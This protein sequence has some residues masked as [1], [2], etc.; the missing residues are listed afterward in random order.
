MRLICPPVNFAGALFPLSLGT[1]VIPRRNE[2]QRFCKIWGGGGG[3]GAN[4]LR[5]R[6]CV[7]GVF[8]DLVYCSVIQN[9]S[10]RCT[11][12]VTR[13]LSYPC[14]QVLENSGNEVAE[15]LG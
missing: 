9:L 13:F 14:Q 15:T 1:A 12:L 8:D 2:K 7:S 3:G 6:R 10:R 5:Y 4:K 11:N